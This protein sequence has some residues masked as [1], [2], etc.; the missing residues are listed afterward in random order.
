MDLVFNRGPSSSRAGLEEDR[1]FLFL[2]STP[3]FLHG[4]IEQLCVEKPD[5][6]PCQQELASGQQMP[7][8]SHSPYLRCFSLRSEIASRVAAGSVVG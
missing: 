1:H 2:F 8:D 3:E 7:L 6:Y 4:D 5:R